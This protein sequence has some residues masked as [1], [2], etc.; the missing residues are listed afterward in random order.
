MASYLNDKVVAF[1]ATGSVN[2][3][4]DQLCIG[5]AHDKSLAG[6]LGGHDYNII[7]NKQDNHYFPY[8]RNPTHY[9][10]SNNVATKY[11][12]PRRR[13]NPADPGRQSTLDLKTHQSTKTENLALN[14]QQ[15]RSTAQMLHAYDYSA[16][17]KQMG[18][19]QP[20][21]PKESARRP[22]T[23]V[24][25][26]TDWN[27]ASEPTDLPSTRRVADWQ[28]RQFGRDNGRHQ[29]MQRLSNAD[30]SITRNN[31]H[32]SGDCKLTRND[33]FFAR[34]AFKYNQPS[35][36]YH[37]ITNERRDFA[38]NTNRQM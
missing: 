4:D 1:T 5:T 12:Y 13:K 38:C 10:D 29:S 33:H 18:E 22:A 9:V 30:F 16:Y 28:Q 23:T 6:S 7:S 11:F 35:V 21:I 31:N 37:I 19:P 34:P 36:T 14:K 32:F 26:M 15:A 25:P 24:V 27:K 20:R 3:Y 2:L 17:Q 8:L